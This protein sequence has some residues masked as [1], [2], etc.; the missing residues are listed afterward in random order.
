LG[1]GSST[2]PASKPKEFVIIISTSDGKLLVQAKNDDDR[3]AWMKTLS[4]YGVTDLKSYAVSNLLAVRSFLDLALMFGFL[5]PSTPPYPLL[6]KANSKGTE[7][8][9]KLEKEVEEQKKETEAAKK[10]LKNAE[11][12]S[13]SLKSKVGDLQEE[14]SSTKKQLAAANRKVEKLESRHQAAVAAVSAPASAAVDN[15]ISGG[16]KTGKGGMFADNRSASG[17]HITTSAGT[18]KMPA[19]AVSMFGGQPMEAMLKP[20][21]APTPAPFESEWVKANDPASGHDY[22]FNHASQESRW[23]DPADP[24][25]PPDAPPDLPAPTM[26]VPLETQHSAKRSSSRP[27]APEFPVP[28][29]A[30]A[31]ETAGGDNGFKPAPGASADDRQ[32]NFFAQMAA[33]KQ[34]KLDEERAHMSPE[35]IAA[36][37]AAKAHEEKQKKMLQKQMR[38]YGGGAKK[39]VGGGRGRGAK[40]S[41]AQVVNGPIM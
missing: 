26:P 14:L 22:W 34:K 1:D 8:I 18:K 31:K 7:E 39:K 19:G 24:D 36:E 41:K 15:P 6:Q 25:R 5:H 16:A 33:D 37:E 3:I 12:N 32:N 38:T 40:R 20:Q 28:Q 23:V 27:P 13:S 2:E 4:S 29:P 17:N 35:D 30:K 10:A 21:A 11:K 9:A